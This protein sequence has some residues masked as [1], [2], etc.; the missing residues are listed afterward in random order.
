MPAPLAEALQRDADGAPILAG[1]VDHCRREVVI[2]NDIGWRMHTLVDF[3]AGEMPVIANWLIEV[4]PAL[5]RI[6]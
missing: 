6:G 1:P 3:V 5:G 2:E 4:F